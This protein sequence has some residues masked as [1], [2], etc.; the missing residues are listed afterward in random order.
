MSAA[1]TWPR[2]LVCSAYCLY[3][4]LFSLP[5]TGAAQAPAVRGEFANPQRVTIRGYDG[6]AMEPFLTR[7]SKYLFLN[8]RTTRA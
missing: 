2:K 4:L 3:A 7:D 5:I 8:N 1:R 6:D